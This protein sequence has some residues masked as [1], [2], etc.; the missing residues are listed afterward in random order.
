MRFLTKKPF[1][2]I[3]YQNELTLEYSPI[4]KVVF[5]VIKQD[6]G[7]IGKHILIVYVINELGKLCQPRAR[8]H[9]AYSL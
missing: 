3:V 8:K 2:L 6:D 1:I 5:R 7:R 9:R 4:V